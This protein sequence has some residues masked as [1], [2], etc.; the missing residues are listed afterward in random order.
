MCSDG[1]AYQADMKAGRVPYDATYLVKCDAYDGSAVAKAVNA[2]RCALLA[3]HLPAG[4]SVLDIGA[5]SGA[6]VRSALWN[7][8]S[9][10]GFDVIP[11]AA[12]RLHQIGH[13]AENPGDFDAVTLWDV[14]EH[15]EDPGP[16]LDSI[17]GFLFVSLPIFDGLW[18]IRKSK[19]YRPGEHL[20]YWQAPAF[21]AWMGLHG[22]RLLEQS[23]HEVA[24]GR[25]SIGAFAFRRIEQ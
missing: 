25:E 16:L 13:Y 7:G 4:A 11:E 9:A 2:G 12:E 23:N 6:F 3:R 1:V 14:L 18:N 21:V 15:I 20:Y 8:F 24:A 5:G 10:A 17:K 22:F 19:H